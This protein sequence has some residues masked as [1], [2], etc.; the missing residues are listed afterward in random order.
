MRIRFQ[1]ITLVR[2]VRIRN[3]CRVTV[4]LDSG[5]DLGAFLRKLRCLLRI[6]Y[7]FYI[8]Y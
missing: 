6:Q 3:V 8:L 5:I 2:T 7:Y 1:H 4:N